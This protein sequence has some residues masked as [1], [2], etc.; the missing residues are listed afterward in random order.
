M[1]SD[2]LPEGLLS[3]S[4]RVDVDAKPAAWQMWEDELVQW[5]SGELQ[6]EGSTKRSKPRAHAKQWI[7]AVDHMLRVVG[8]QGFKTFQQAPDA[9]HIATP[10]PHLSIHIDQGSD[11]WAAC[12]F[13]CFEKRLN[14]TVIFDSS[15]RVWNDC[16]LALQRSNLWGVV[17]LTTIVYNLDHGP[18]K[19]A[20]WYVQLREAA[21]LFT[22]TQSHDSSSLF[23]LLFPAM[24]RDTGDL[25]ATLFDDE[26]VQVFASLPEVFRTQTIKVSLTRWFQWVDTSKD[27]LKNWHRRLLVQLWLCIHSGIKLKGVN[28]KIP[29]GATSETTSTAHE[30]DQLRAL[31]HS[32]KNSLQLATTVLADPMLRRQVQ[33]LVCRD[34][35]EPVRG[36]HSQQS[37]TLRSAPES[38]QW[39][40][41]QSAGAGLSELSSIVARLHS[42]VV[43]ELSHGDLPSV[44][45][46]QITDLNHPVVIEE[47]LLSEKAAHLTIALL[48]HRVWSQMWHWKALPGILPA[49]LL[50]ETRQA[51]IAQLQAWHKAW[52]EVDRQ[53][54]AFWAKIRNRSPFRL[55][56]VQQVA[57]QS[58]QTHEVLSSFGMSS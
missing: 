2:L 32:C 9:N 40:A 5:L 49:L 42:S 43:A 48:T 11:G 23:R 37:R 36:W 30:S 12:M 44:V 3:E 26:A 45:V 51:T 46:A 22:K 52:L 41:K 6:E 25:E 47:D 31:R 29:I 10:H 28:I 13:L 21:S 19:E 54:G 14:A 38:L 56:L 24:L 1:L 18:W 34:L 55:A 53:M 58:P 7:V 17:L 4:S 33:L 16:R 50:D 8:L 27:F 20:R 35:L 39:F 15:H 57:V